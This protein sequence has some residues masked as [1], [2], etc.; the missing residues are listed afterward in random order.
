MNMFNPMERLCEL[1]PEEKMK[2]FDPVENFKEKTNMK[3]MKTNANVLP[4]EFTK[5]ELSA[6]MRV[7]QAMQID[8]SKVTV[9]VS[10]EP[11]G[12]VKMNINMLLT[13]NEN[14]KIRNYTKKTGIKYATLAK[15]A[16][17]EYINNH[18]IA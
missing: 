17:L 5:E 10:E 18:E 8:N 15:Y 1:N 13:Q 2:E 11:K 16:M 9:K 7:I 12:K 14:T 4:Q 3:E 6:A